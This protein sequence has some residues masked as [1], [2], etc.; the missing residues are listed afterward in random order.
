[1]GAVKTAKLVF[2]YIN[3]RALKYKWDLQEKKIQEP[4]WFTLSEEQEIEMENANIESTQVHHTE[5]ED[6]EF[7]YSENTNA[8]SGGRDYSETG[9]DDVR[10]LVPEVEI[11]KLVSLGY[12]DSQ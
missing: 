2:I 12:F 9:D 4:T 11:T 5:V 7:E 3:S 10:E 8:N 1:M 6:M